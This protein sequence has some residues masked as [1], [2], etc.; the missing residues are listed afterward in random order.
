MPYGAE[1][2]ERATAFRLWAP[3]VARVDLILGADAR[4]SELA[5]SARDGGWY[6]RTVDGVGAGTPY[7][8]RI[9]RG[10]T[11][12]DPASRANPDGVHGPSVVVDPVGYAW[13]DAPW[14]G[15]AWDEAVLYEL[16]IGTFTPGGTFA[17]A[18]ERLDDLADLGITA[19][20][21][22]PVA[23]FPGVRNW[24][25]DGVLPFAPA[26][27]YGTPDD[28]KRLVDEA[29]ARGL[30]ILLDVVYNHF[31][32]EGNYLHAYAP[33]F[34]NPHHPTPWGAAINF[35]GD[36]CRTVREFFIHNACYWL[37]EFHFDG[38]RLDAVHAI[39][40]TS[41]PDF[42]SELASRVRTS[43][44]NARHVH[45]VLENDRNEARYLGRD[46]ARRPSVA[47]AQWNEDLH[48]SLHV[49]A[50]GE[51]DGYYADYAA[52]PLACFGRAL[53]EGFVYQGQASAYRG[54]APRGE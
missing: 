17:A 31:G 36:D 48:H 51:R 11:V 29:H 39:V 3:A 4:R 46:A 26:S 49:L 10:I 37:E 50:T 20:E 1:F 8:F 18:I 7:A 14:R 16:H 43:F 15:R 44:A 35:D 30:M 22:M 53:A 28:L 9:D 27:S 32:P 47:T 12:P 25:Y 42:V 41:Q 40:D 6:E 5:L 33:Q 45:L 23:A 21:L 52:D 2:G 24:G 38:L 19:I 34:F 13:R 54:G